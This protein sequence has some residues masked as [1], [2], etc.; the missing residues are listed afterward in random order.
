MWPPQDEI[1]SNYFIYNSRP[2][3]RKNKPAT[4]CLRNWKMADKIPVGLLITPASIL[5]PISLQSVHF[6]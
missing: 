3:S 2:H 4:R 5:S 6:Q 1:R